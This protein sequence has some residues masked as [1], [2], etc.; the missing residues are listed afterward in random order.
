MPPVIDDSLQ[1]A[2]LGDLLAST[3]AGVVRAQSVLDARAAEQAAAHAALPEN[4]PN[5]PPLAFHVRS[6][7]IEVA[8]AATFSAGTLVCRLVN[9]HSVSLFGYQAA[10]GTSVAMVIEPRPVVRA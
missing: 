7:R 4:A 8:M 2:A 5:P 10:S 6:A 1:Q 3:V 9:P